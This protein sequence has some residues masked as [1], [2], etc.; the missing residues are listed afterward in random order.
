MQGCICQL[1]R[2]KLLLDYA[3]TTAP[4]VAL[5][6]NSRYACSLKQYNSMSAARNV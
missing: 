1:I 6:M 2:S 3:R 5:T 4:G